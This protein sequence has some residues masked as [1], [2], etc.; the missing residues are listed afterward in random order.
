MEEYVHAV[1]EIASVLK[2]KNANEGNVTREDKISM[3]DDESVELNGE[4]KLFV[5]ARGCEGEAE[6][7]QTDYAATSGAEECVKL[8]DVENG[9][10]TSAAL[11]AYEVPSLKQIV[12][13]YLERE[14]CNEDHEMINRT[15]D[16]LNSKIPKLS[17]LCKIALSSSFEINTTNNNTNQNTPEP[18]ERE[19]SVEE[20][21]AEM[22]RQAGVTSDPEDGDADEKEAQQEDVV[23]INLEEI[24]VNDS[25]LYV[26]Q[27]DMNENVLSVVAHAQPMPMEE[28]IENIERELNSEILEEAMILDNTPKVL[29]MTN[30]T[31]NEN[32]FNETFMSLHEEEKGEEKE[33]RVESS[34]LEALNAYITPTH[35]LDYVDDDLRITN[36]DSLNNTQYDFPAIHHEEIVA[37][38]Y[39]RHRRQVLYN[40]LREKYVLKRVNFRTQHGN[41]VLKKYIH[42]WILQCLISR[43]RE[44]ELRKTQAH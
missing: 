5:A 21:L 12:L 43:F 13:I 33:L 2:H 32:N 35:T 15:E 18:L 22:Y 28:S 3:V 36:D 1:E 6:G 4:S 44:R 30:E 24:L 9:A 16:A 23:L 14:K 8:C 10:T 40:S 25:D 20:A 26:L 41:R 34:G 29:L 42:R 37:H 39:R 27:C 7:V 19:L 38:D 31:L 17:D 11:H